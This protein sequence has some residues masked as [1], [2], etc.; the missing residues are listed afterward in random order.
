VKGGRRIASADLDAGSLVEH[1]RYTLS[2]DPRTGVR[3]VRTLSAYLPL[4]RHCSAT[5]SASAPQN[6]RFRLGS[7]P[8]QSGKRS[9]GATHKLIK[10]FGNACC[11]RCGPQ[12]QHQS[13]WIDGQG[14]ASAISV[15]SVTRPCAVSASH[16]ERK[17]VSSKHPHYVRS[18]YSKSSIFS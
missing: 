1:K 6:E 3:A 13:D 12:F 16:M 9:H 10:S 15:T 18:I 7:Q 5:E 17:S 2:D 4:C 14:R 11:A 8:L